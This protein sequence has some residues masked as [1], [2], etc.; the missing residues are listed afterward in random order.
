MQTVLEQL[1]M[2]ELDNE[3]KKEKTSTELKEEQTYD[4]L[5][6]SLNKGQCELFDEFIELISD[7][8]AERQ[9]ETYKWGF[10]SALRLVK[11][12]QE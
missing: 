11:E 8:L 1:Y 7:R 2:L 5:R 10:R 6:K 12:L 9:E 3:I 4:V